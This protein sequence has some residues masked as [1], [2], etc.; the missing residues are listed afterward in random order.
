[1]LIPC[2]IL[3][4]RQAE[5]ASNIVLGTL[6][7]EQQEIAALQ[8]FILNRVRNLVVFKNDYFLIMFL[9]LSIYSFM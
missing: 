4:Y 5:N 8:M 6:D 2:T 7:K 9:L 3:T 1:M